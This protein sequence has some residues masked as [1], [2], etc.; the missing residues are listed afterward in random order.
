MRSSF[1]LFSFLLSDISHFVLFYGLIFFTSF[2]V[3][4]LNVSS[5]VVCISTQATLIKI[6]I[7]GGLICI[8][9][10]LFQVILLVKSY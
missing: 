8:P 6:L 9:G 5:A 1:T 10:Q 4:T 2:T 7:Y 3:K